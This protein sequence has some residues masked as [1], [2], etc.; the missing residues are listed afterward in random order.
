[1]RSYD[2][3]DK[4]DHWRYPLKLE[5]IVKAIIIK[6]P[7]GLDRVERIEQPDP[8]P[9]GPGA[10]RVRLHASS[11]NFHD[12]GVVITPNR[13]SDGRIPMSDGAGIVEAV[14]KGVTEFKVN[15]RVVCCFS[16]AGWMAHRLFPISRPFRV[17]ELMDTRAR[18]WWRQRPPSPARRR[19]ILSPKRFKPQPLSYRGCRKRHA[20]TLRIGRA[21]SCRKMAAA[22]SE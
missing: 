4:I 12:Y 22:A 20:R 15:D 2:T 18:S 21:R 3:N 13:V 7:G 14:G 1:M 19:A 8:G 10:L 11:L 9:P 5:I 17:M 16:P 6:A